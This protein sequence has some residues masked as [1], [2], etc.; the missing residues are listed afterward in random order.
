MRG[1]QRGHEAFQDFGGWAEEGDGSVG[2]AL[3]FGLAG[4]QKR[5]YDGVLPYAR[6]AGMCIGE[7]EKPAQVAQ[8][9][10]TKVLQLK[11]RETIGTKSSGAP[12][13][14]QGLPH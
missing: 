4:F 5:H 13:A 14:L 6:N 10:G 12:T 2:V 11:H 8:A 9:K 7:V 1:D 3:L